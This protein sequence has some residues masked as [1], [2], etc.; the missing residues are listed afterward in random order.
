MWELCLFLLLLNFDAF[1]TGLAFGFAGV[2]ITSGACLLVAALSALYLIAKYCGQNSRNGLAG[3]WRRPEA[4]DNNA[5][6]RIT[7]KE[8]ALL[9]VALALDSLG[10]GLAL[11][12][13]LENVWLY[14]LLSAVFCY[15][16]LVFANRLA[17]Y[18]ARNLQK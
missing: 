14:T 1:L 4:V 18:I 13:L 15:I 3:L 10:G 17:Y 12:I 16:L 6:K 5:D 7:P 8:A 2:R 11:G 9:G